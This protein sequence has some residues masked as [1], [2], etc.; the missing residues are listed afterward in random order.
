MVADYCAYCA[1]GDSLVGKLV[2]EFV[3]YSESNSRPWL[4][5]YVCGDNGW[6]LNEHGMVSKFLHY[7]RDLNTPIIVVSSDRKRF[8]AGKVVTDFACFVDMAPTFLAAAGIDISPFDYDYLDGRDLA[9]TAA[10]AV[11]LRPETDSCTR[12]RCRSAQTV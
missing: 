8:P 7:D 3:A 11:P 6:K 9:M 2:D 12:F 4:I 10:G 5:L 1:Y